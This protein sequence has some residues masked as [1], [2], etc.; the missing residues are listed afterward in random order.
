MSVL[1]PETVLRKPELEIGYT[2][3]LQFPSPEILVPPLQ[4]GQLLSNRLQDLAG[5]VLDYHNF[6]YRF[7][8]HPLYPVRHFYDKT[9]GV[10]GVL[11]ELKIAE[12]KGLSKKQF[13]TQIYRGDKIP[14][15]EIAFHSKSYNKDEQIFINQAL[16]IIENG[17]DFKSAS[18]PLEGDQ[19]KYILPDTHLSLPNKQ[20]NQYYWLYSKFY[21]LHGIIGSR[22]TETSLQGVCCLTFITPEELNRII[23]R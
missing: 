15:L 12:A 1:N 5:K 8:K 21:D 14:K 23:S 20:F 22:A 11:K 7:L 18:P 16:L 3:I 19:E 17:L 6:D 2:K 9:L 10:S 4:T 13:G